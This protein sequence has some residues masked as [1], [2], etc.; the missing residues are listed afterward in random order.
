MLSKPKLPAVICVVDCKNNWI[1]PLPLYCMNL[2]SSI[3]QKSIQLKIKMLGYAIR[4]NFSPVKSSTLMSLSAKLAIFNLAIWISF[5]YVV[6]KNIAILATFYMSHVNQ[7]NWP[8]ISTDVCFMC[9]VC[10]MSKIEFLKILQC[11]LHVCT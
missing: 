4:R 3:S 7:R 10:G 2:I 6:I 5:H 1:Y 11:H 8:K 9:R